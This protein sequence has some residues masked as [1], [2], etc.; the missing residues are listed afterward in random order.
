MRQKYATSAIV[1]ARYP[2]GESNA[3][4]ALLTPELGLLRARAQGV[5]K[6]GAK[7]AAALQTLAESEVMLVRGKEGWRLSGAVLRHNHFSELTPEARERAGR[8]A[9]LILRLVKGESR[10]DELYA[11]MKDLLEAL[12]TVEPEAQEAAEA[13]AALLVL[14]ALGLDEGEVSSEEDRFGAG[15]L[16]WAN[17]HRRDLIVRIN[18]GIGASGL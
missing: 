15:A 10:D 14:R 1:L 12:A 17:E 13:I 8:I 6:Q 16:A 4:V 18:R 3:S 7:L 2:H 9:G 5:R 11:L